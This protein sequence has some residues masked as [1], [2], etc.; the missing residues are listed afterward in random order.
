MA[1][2]LNQLVQEEEVTSSKDKDQSIDITSDSTI[3]NI[4]F[5]VYKP[6]KKTVK[7]NII[8]SDTNES[9][10]YADLPSTSLKNK[11]KFIIDDLNLLVREIDGLGSAFAQ[12][13]IQFKKDLLSDPIVNFIEQWYPAI[14]DYVLKYGYKET[15]KGQSALFMNPDEISD[16]LT[17]CMMS[18][19][20]VLFIASLEEYHQKQ[21]YK[22]LYKPLVEKK[23]INKILGLLGSKISPFRHTDTK[24]WLFLK[25]VVAKTPET[26]TFDLLWFSLQ[27]VFPVCSIN[28]NPIVYLLS[29]ANECVKWIVHGV[30]SPPEF[31]RSVPTSVTDVS[32]ALNNVASMKII[33]LVKQWCLH[34]TSESRRDRIVNQLANCEYSTSIQLLMVKIFKNIFNIAGS[35]IKG[36]SPEDIAYICWFLYKGSYTL[37]AYNIKQIEQDKEKY[38]NWM[39][40]STLSNIQY[41]DLDNKKGRHNNKRLSSSP[42]WA[43]IELN[44]SR[45]P[46]EILSKPGLG[47]LLKCIPIAKQKGSSISVN[48]LLLLSLPINLKGISIKK[49]ARDLLKQ[50]F[51]DV[52]LYSYI[53][54]ETDQPYTPHI[55][56]CMLDLLTLLY[57]KT[58][59]EG[60]YDM[61]Q[62]LTSLI[63]ESSLSNIDESVKKASLSKSCNE[64]I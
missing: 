57:H 35:I 50:T 47:K 3:S 33:E 21:V 31:S 11:C 55:S 1:E 4:R 56:K 34:N 54:I 46:L 5:E 52:N 64:Y 23:L 22:A 28:Q 37:C 51:Q 48:E 18:K 49:I 25:L 7:I 53:D 62:P 9:I 14:I 12:T 36:L 63:R 59:Y 32:N 44:L 38:H 8:N 19:F 39:H 17:V 24:M 43:S 6:N 40:P 42:P 15:Q 61:L 30:Y 45:H 58:V 27:N 2:T 10:W 41:N 29:V 13:I 20:A 26:H 60:L 16:V